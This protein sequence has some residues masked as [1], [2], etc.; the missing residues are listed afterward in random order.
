MD[1]ESKNAY[2]IIGSIAVIISLIFNNISP[3][4]FIGIMAYID[5]DK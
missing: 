3:I 2:F 4:I 1:V 5:N